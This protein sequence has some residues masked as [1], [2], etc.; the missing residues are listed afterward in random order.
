MLFFLDVVVIV[1]EFQEVSIY[2]H[3]VILF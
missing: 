2:L 3:N 1:V